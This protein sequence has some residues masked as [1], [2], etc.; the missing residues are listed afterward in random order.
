MRRLQ[1]CCV[2]VN[3]LAG[4]THKHL[5]TLGIAGDSSSSLPSDSDD[6]ESVS[7]GTGLRRRFSTVD[8]ERKLMFA[9]FGLH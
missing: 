8:G 5:I 4:K 7:R 2:V 6:I 9:R 3:G 1:L